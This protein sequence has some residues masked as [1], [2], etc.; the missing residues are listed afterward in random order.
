MQRP[1]HSALSLVLLI[2]AGAPLHAQSRPAPTVTSDGVLQSKRP[3]PGAVYESAPFT[4]AVGKG[5]RTRTGMP[6]TRNWVQHARYT[7]DASLDNAT[8][9][10]WGKEHVVYLNNSPDTLPY[11]LIHLR[12]NVFKPEAH[13]SDFAPLS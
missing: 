8:H 5:T 1:L 7:I 9:K 11:L 4:I 12:Q 2:C 10:V 6:G 3:I 13:R